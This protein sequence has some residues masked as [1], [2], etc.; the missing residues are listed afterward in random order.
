ME[1]AAKRRV[2]GRATANGLACGSRGF[3]AGRQ[4]LG[5]PLE[6]YPVRGYAPGRR[7]REEKDSPGVRRPRGATVLR[8]VGRTDELTERKTLSVAL[9]RDPQ[10]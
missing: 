7:A 6:G 2:D 5:L 10:R 1:R 3:E 9:S 4:R 8:T